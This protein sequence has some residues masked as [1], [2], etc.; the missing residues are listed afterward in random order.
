MAEAS[1]VSRFDIN[2]ELSSIQP[3]AIELDHHL[4]LAIAHQREV[5]HLKEVLKLLLDVCLS[6]INQTY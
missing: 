2:G 6:A 4:V 3:A 1:A 5:Y